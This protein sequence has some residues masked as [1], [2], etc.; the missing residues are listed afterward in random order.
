MVSSMLRSMLNI[1]MVKAKISLVET[2]SKTE[3]NSEVKFY[4]SCGMENCVEIL[5]RNFLSTSSNSLSPELLPWF[6]SEP[7]STC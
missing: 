7:L 2:G 4:S 1:T 3:N 5:V 6:D